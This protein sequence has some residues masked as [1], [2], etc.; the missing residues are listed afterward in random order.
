MSETDSEKANMADLIK[1][2]EEKISSL[3]NAV[4]EATDDLSRLRTGFGFM[5]NDLSFGKKACPEFLKDSEMLRRLLK[6]N[7]EVTSTCFEILSA[8]NQCKLCD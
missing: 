4:K 1:Q 6:D 8:S 7:N 2:Q 5:I 3:E